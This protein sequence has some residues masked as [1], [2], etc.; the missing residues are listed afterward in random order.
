MERRRRLWRVRE[1]WPLITPAAPPV[2]QRG[3]SRARRDIAWPDT[4]RQLTLSWAT[5]LAT[6]DLA[7]PTSAPPPLPALG[8]EARA[9]LDYALLDMSSRS[10]PLRALR[11]DLRR[12][13]VWT[14]AELAEL[15]AGQVTQAAGWV[16]ST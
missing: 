10:H 15:P 12:C 9:A 14:I 3:R 4:P 8:A 11:R 1:V 5:A 2:K 7:T 13:G 6:P 16:I